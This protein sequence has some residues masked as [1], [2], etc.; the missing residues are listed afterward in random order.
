MI[1]DKKFGFIGQNQPKKFVKSSLNLIKREL[2][3]ATR[4]K[5]YNKN[6]IKYIYLLNYQ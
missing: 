6:A 2:N 3:T 4:T 5:L 1:W